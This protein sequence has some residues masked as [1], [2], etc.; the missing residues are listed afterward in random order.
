MF[1]TW[2]R[3]QEQNIYKCVRLFYKKVEWKGEEKIITHYMQEQ[4]K[5]DKLHFI[6]NEADL[7]YK[8]SSNK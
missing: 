1:G 2:K 6:L 4:K 5:Q 3:T 7:A 8:N